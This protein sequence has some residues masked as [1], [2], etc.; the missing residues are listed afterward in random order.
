MKLIAHAAIKSRTMAAAMHRASNVV[1]IERDASPPNVL[2]R[3]G[4][5]SYNPNN[6]LQ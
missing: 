6:D 4:V 3:L 2:H 5:S 1:N